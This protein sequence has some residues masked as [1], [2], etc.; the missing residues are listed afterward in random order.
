VALLAAKLSEKALWP[1]IPFFGGQGYMPVKEDAM[2]IKT[3]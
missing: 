1:E 3:G 2:H